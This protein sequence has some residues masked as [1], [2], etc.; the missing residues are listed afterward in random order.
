[1]SIDRFVRVAMLRL[2]SLFHRNV[3]EEELDDELQYHLE[4]ETA[5]YVRRGLSARDARD[6][7]RRGLGNV[8]YRKEEVRDTRGT[9]WIEEFLG[10]VHFALRSLR[11][12]RGFAATVILTLALG[13][14]ANT[15]MFT[16]LRGTLLRQL[17]NR[18]GDRLVYLRQEAPGAK[19]QDL[20]FSVPEVTDY[21]A[22]TK[23]LASFAEYSQA[24]PTTLVG[25][26]G[27]PERVRAAVIT[28]NYFDVLGLEQVIGRTTNSDD[29]GAS[30]ASVAV[31]SFRYWSEH[32]GGDPHVIGQKLRLNGSLSTV[33]GVVQPAPDYPQPTDIF[34]NTVT[35][36]H[37]L[38][39]TMVTERTHRMSQLFAR[40]APGATIGQA[41]RELASIAERMF[42]DHP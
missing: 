4:M 28:G 3:V 35:S 42:R 15:A 17:P 11:R 31:L 14:G 13:I 24:L 9:R 21:R 16:L 33:I 25:T 38:S 5:A 2:R 32:F 7:A 12:S 18:D 10:D 30:A 37:H 8:A 26:D 23:T 29:D 34:V 22:S 39:A 40:I 27:R 36:P 6:A 19:Q 1:M 20:G 41:R